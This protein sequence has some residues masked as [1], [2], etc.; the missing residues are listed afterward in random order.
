MAYRGSESC[1]RFEM[2]CSPDAASAGR[3]LV[4][5]GFVFDACCMLH[6]LVSLAQLSLA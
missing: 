1:D 2:V 5:S 4:W 6:G 3:T